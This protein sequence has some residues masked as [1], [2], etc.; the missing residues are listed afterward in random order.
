M[1]LKPSKCQFFKEKVRFME[2]VVSKDGVATDPKKTEAVREWRLP[3]NVKE[4]RSW[5]G[6]TGYY[7]RFMK[8][9]TEIAK[10]LHELTKKEEKFIWTKE[11][12]NGF[13]SPNSQIIGCQ[14]AFHTGNRRMWMQ[15]RRRT[16]TDTG[17]PGKGHCLW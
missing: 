5:I 10:P 6:M 17:W 15:H 11:R 13:I 16:V 7:R 2:H 8:T 12:D 4:V 14:R 3:R 1:K 9:Y